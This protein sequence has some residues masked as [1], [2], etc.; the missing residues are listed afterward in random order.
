MMKT[1]FVKVYPVVRKS[2]VLFKFFEFRQYMKIQADV[3]VRNIRSDNGG[4]HTSTDMKTYCA[5]EYQTGIYDPA[6]PSA[7]WHG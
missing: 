7:E 2:D 6:Q 1:G 4:K 3:S 5:K